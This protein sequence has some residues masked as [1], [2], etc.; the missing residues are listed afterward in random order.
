MTWNKKSFLVFAC[1]AAALTLAISLTGFPQ[2][3][4]V[5]AG[6]AAGAEEVQSLRA[7]AVVASVLTSPRCLNCHVA[8]DSPLQGDSGIPHNMNVKRGADGRGMPAMRCTN[9][10]QEENSTQLHAPPGRRD[11]RL[12]PPSN[13]LAWQ[14][15]SFGDI[16]RVLKDPVTNGGKSPDQLIEHVRADPFV[17]WGWAP[18]PGRSTPPVSHD[19]FVTQVTAW[20]QN[21]AACPSQ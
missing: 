21:G 2:G 1:A 10:H 20:L 9:C 8:G 16:C 19:Q 3:K 4:Q 18:G 17:N 5:S 6:A 7:F 14:G 11:W 15:L 12:P 13:R